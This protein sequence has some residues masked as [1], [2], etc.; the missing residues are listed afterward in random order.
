[1]I[2]RKSEVGNGSWAGI[3]RDWAMIA[4]I[5]YTL[6]RTAAAADELRFPFASASRAWWSRL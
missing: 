1:M 2:R 4:V 3:F 6:A 5:Y